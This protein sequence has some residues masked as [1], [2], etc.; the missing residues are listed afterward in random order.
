M[1][2]SNK[3]MFKLLCLRENGT[4]KRTFELRMHLSHTLGLSAAV[5]RRDIEHDGSAL[6]M[7]HD[8]SAV[9]Q[10]VSTIA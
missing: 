2:Y 6:P 10:T 8:S 4:Y 7:H 9:C 5:K 1:I 3:K